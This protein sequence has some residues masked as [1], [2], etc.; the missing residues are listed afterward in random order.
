MFN[1]KEYMKQWHLDNPDYDKQYRLD[2]KDKINKR[3]RQW[4]KDNPK[5]VKGFDLRK[6]YGL[7][8]NEWVGLWYSQDGRCAICDKFFPNTFEMCVDHNHDTGEI[9]GLLCRKCNSAL[10]FFLD[11]PESLVNA[12]E[13]IVQ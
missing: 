1:Q 6:N 13:Y 2:N 7:S 3:G 5:Y 4:R 8:Y 11:N 9:R 12:T 10:G